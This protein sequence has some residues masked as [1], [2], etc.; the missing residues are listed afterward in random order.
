LREYWALEEKLSKVGKEL[1]I[2][3]KS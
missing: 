3:I 1:W 2:E